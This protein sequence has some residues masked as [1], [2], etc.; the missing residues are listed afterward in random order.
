LGAVAGVAARPRT[1]VSMEFGDSLL[2]IG[3]GAGQGSS[4]TSDVI[5]AEE[6][7]PSAAYP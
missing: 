4:D 7:P 5:V 3:P 6:G 1:L 2:V